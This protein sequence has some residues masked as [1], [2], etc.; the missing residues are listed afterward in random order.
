MHSFLPLLAG[1][2]LLTPPAAAQSQDHGAWT[3]RCEG[4]GTNRQ[5]ETFQRLTDKA[6][7][8]RVIELAIGFTSPDKLARPGRIAP[9]SVAAAHGENA[10][11]AMVLPLGVSLTDGVTLNLDKKSRHDFQLRYCTPDGCYA[12]LTLSRP[13]LDQFSRTLTASITFRTMDGEDV[14]LPID[15]K[16]FSSALQSIR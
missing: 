4:Q 9:P 10:R 6:T 13:I 12:Y 15:P 16:G 1:L 2:L 5:C 3:I 8:E 7:G 14:T 11:A